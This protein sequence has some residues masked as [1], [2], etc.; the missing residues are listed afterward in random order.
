MQKNKYN[1]IAQS[2]LALLA[3]AQ[4][5][6]G[7][8]DTY[9]YTGLTS[10][11]LAWNRPQENDILTPNVLSGI[12]TQVPYHVFVFTVDTTGSYSL[13][14]IASAPSGW[15]NYVTLYAGAF[16]AANPLQNAR[17]SNDDTVFMTGQASVSS[18]TLTAGFPYFLVT[19]GFSNGDYGSFSNTI[20]GPGKTVP[21]SAVARISLEGVSNLSRAYGLTQVVFGFRSPGSLTANLTLTVTPVADGSGSAY[22]YCAISGVPAGTYD[23]AI[24][25]PRNLQV[26][27]PNVT[28]ADFTVL[29]DAFL[30]AGDANNDNSVDSSDFGVIIGAYNTTAA[31]P[32]DGYDPTADFNYDGVVDSTDFGL[33][34]G[35]FGAQGAT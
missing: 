16:S 28:V 4:T 29:P 6:A 18:V 21:V 20:S 12:G 26:V 24:K 30:G 2:L 34:I 33:L 35:E 5:A 32:G 14:S 13:S 23:V 10:P 1:L 27:L 19:S 7:R 9:N 15:D 25:N 11:A 8:A 3:L 22:G 17:V 31:I